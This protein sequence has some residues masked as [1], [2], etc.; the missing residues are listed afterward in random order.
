MNSRT[1]TTHLSAVALVVLALVAGGLSVLALM[2]N[3][4][5]T[6]MIVSS[7]ATAMDT[8]TSSPA[9]QKSVT[10]SQFPPSPQST[11]G[12]SNTTLSDISVVVLG[13]SHS[14]PDTPSVWVNLAAAEL[15]WT[16]MENISA[17]GR[18]YLA[19]PSTCNISVCSN[20]EG[21]IPA[22]V[23]QHPDVVV[24]FGGM[25]DGDR[26]LS[27]TAMQYF[28]ALRMALPDAALIAISPVT[29]GDDA[30]YFLRLHD[31]TIRAGV[32]AAGGTFI[33]VGRPG[34]GDGDQLSADA[35]NDIAQAVIAELS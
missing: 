5:P 25:A 7:D 1:S 4:T 14:A 3:S 2:Q 28:A 16:R 15:E 19:K 32:E 24:T 31:Q 26:D 13:D 20:F 33:D 21:S 17:Q 29:S 10:Q 34:V 18:G 27:D 11:L 12:D 9:P 30:P 6:P 8:F 35:Q 23:E 22:V